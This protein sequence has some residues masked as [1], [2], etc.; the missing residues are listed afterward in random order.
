MISVE[1]IL[2]CL[3]CAGVYLLSVS[4]LLVWV[5]RMIKL[6]DAIPERLREPS[7]PAWFGVNF[8][9]E[10]LFLVAIPTFAYSYFYVVLP[11]SGVRA[12]VMIVLVAFVFGATPVLMTLWSR[13]N[14]SPLLMIYSLLSL[15]VKLGGSLI[16]IGYLYTL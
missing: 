8:L 15:L 10:Y 14:L 2:Y 7:G 12:A 13:V 16:I 1:L 6:T 4:L 9:L 5:G 11:L 3:V